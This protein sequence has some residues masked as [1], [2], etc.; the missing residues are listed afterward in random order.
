MQSPPAQET[1]QSQMRK[2][3]PA[4]TNREVLDLITVWGEESVQ[5]ELRSKKR[6]ANI[7][8]KISWNMTDR[9]YSRDTQQCRVKIKELRQVYQKTREAN[10]RSGSQPH[11]CRFYDELHAILGGDA[12]TTPPPSVDT[13]KG[14]LSRSGK[15]DFEEEEE[16]EA[17]DSAQAASGE[18]VLPGS[19]ELFITLEPI[20]S[21][22]SHFWHA[23]IR[24]QKKRTRDDMFA[25]LMQSS[26]T[27]RAQL[28]A[29]RKQWQSPGKHSVTAMRG[30]ED[31]MLK[32]MGEQTDMLRCLV[33]LMRER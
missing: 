6:N 28:N 25:K 20:L 29:R 8:A 3:A 16:E 17:E 13:C 21:T 2:R 4:W 33:D 10:R 18:S 30:K 1:M 19:Q 14:G 15:D 32:L 23:Q 27:D 22:P 12:T 7:F 9:G 24:R 11:T 5:A 26:C 31:A